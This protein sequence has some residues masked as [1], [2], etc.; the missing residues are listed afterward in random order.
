MVE[1]LN[2]ARTNK[3]TVFMDSAGDFTLVEADA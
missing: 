1:A 3:G 2:L